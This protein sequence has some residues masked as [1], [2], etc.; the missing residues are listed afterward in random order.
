MRE[1]G[2]HAERSHREVAETALAAG[3][4]LVCGIGEFADALRRLAPADDRVVTAGDVDDLWPL[5]E[6]RLLPDAAILLKASR[7]VRLERIV[8]LLTA[9][10]AQ[11]SPTA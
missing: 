7:G 6:P 5:L 9:W 8:P 1:L 3:L 10:A 11:H 2:T 4:D